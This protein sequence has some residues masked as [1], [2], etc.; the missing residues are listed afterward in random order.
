[1]TNTITA[2]LISNVIVGDNGATFIPTVTDGGLIS[3]VNDKGLPN[4]QIVNIKGDTPQVSATINS[5]G[6]LIITV[7]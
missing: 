2:E 4:P 1:M 3:W 7:I 5:K 6:E